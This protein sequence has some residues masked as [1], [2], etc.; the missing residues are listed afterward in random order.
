MLEL[1]YSFDVLTDVIV[2]LTFLPSFTFVWLCLSHF[3]SRFFLVDTKTARRVRL[4][5]RRSVSFRLFR[6]RRFGFALRAFNLFASSP[7][8]SMCMLASLCLCQLLILYKHTRACALAHILTYIVDDGKRGTPRKWVEERERERRSPHTLVHKMIVMLFAR[9][10]TVGG[11]RILAFRSVQMTT[12]MMS[13]RVALLH[14]YGWYDFSSALILNCPYA[15]FSF[16]QYINYNAY[17]FIYHSTNALC[18]WGCISRDRKN[19]P[20]F[21]E[22]DGRLV[23]LTR[24]LMYV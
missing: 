23:D 9:Y 1:F 8:T 24:I 4:Y 7:Y 6:S 12:M 21:A 22:I 20:C 18:V 13:C 11:K 5:S 3:L 2:T 10:T 17:R 19:V 15:L 14:S 16:C